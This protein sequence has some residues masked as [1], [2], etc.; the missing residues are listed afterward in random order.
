MKITVLIED[1]NGTKN[2]IASHGLS[3]HVETPVH[4]LLVDTG[5][6]DDTWY[7]AR[8]LGINLAAIDTVVISHG[9]YDHTGGLIGLAKINPNIDI[10]IHQNAFGDF[11]HDN[12]YIGADKNIAS[13]KNVHTVGNRH[14]IDDELSLFSDISG[15]RL[16]PS[17][18]LVLSEIKNNVRIQDSFSHEQCL[19]INSGQKSVLISGCAHNGILNIID[20][21]RE[22]Y[23][24]YPDA[25]I[26]GFHMMKKGEYTAREKSDIKDTA[27]ELS[28]MPTVF[29]T[30]HC[31]GQPAIRI[32][33]EIMCDNLIE[34]HSG[35][36]FVI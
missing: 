19:V 18:N 17:S 12:R 2:V 25:V 6:S 33:K 7:N 1:T 5:A 36:E 27:R 14:I 15:R 22:L 34:L 10:Y 32:M 23:N 28:E 11:Y 21:Y 26:S 16:W 29:Y 24:S 30:G 8:A 9:H 3:I 35:D 31:S 4:S 20:K 13:F